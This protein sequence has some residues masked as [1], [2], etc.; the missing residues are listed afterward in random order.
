MEG[1]LKRDWAGGRRV[2]GHMSVEITS[3]ICDRDSFVWDC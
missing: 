1:N 2:K 3:E